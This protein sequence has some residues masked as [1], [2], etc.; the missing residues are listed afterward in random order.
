MSLTLCDGLGSR[1]RDALGEG[2]EDERGRSPAPRSRHDV[3]LPALRSRGRGPRSRRPGR[4]ADVSY[5]HDPRSAGALLAG[6]PAAA[7]RCDR[8][9]GTVCRRAIKS[10]RAVYPPRC[11]DIT[12][13]RP[14]TELGGSAPTE[15]AECRFVRSH[16]APRQPAFIKDATSMQTSTPQPATGR[17]APTVSQ[18]VDHQRRQARRG[19]WW[20]AVSLSFR[21]PACTASSAC[22]PIGRCPSAGFGGG[23]RADR[24][25]ARTVIHRIRVAKRG[26]SPLRRD[27]A[28][29][30]S[31]AHRL[32]DLPL[33]PPYH[34]I[35]RKVTSMENSTESSNESRFSVSVRP[36][37]C[38]AL[39]SPQSSPLVRRWLLR[40]APIAV[41]RPVDHSVSAN[42]SRI[43][44]YAFARH[45]RNA[46]VHME[47][48]EH[49]Q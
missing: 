45:S 13:R 25:A 12:L 35:P 20:S 15:T 22:L 43:A 31:P 30:A 14:P 39:P 17:Y 7:R 9:R 46:S 24:S 47:T 2:D 16:A 44:A 26:P 27:G 5:D 21:R 29:Q 37:T 10:R 41:S 36:L 1:R 6:V 33:N 32:V 42:M 11:G 3:G 34:S 48:K 23:A 4:A 8:G 38:E 19:Y 40:Y 28:A 49:I 18:P